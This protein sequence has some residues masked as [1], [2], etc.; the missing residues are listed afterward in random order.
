MMPS[1][2]HEEKESNR[3]LFCLRIKIY[4]DKIIL[5]KIA[6]RVRLIGF[7]TQRCG[8]ERGV[9][10]GKHRKRRRTACRGFGVTAR[11]ELFHPAFCR[12]R[13]AFINERSGGLPLREEEQPR[14]QP[15]R[16][17]RLRRSS[18]ALH[19]ECARGWRH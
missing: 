5:S 8:I 16:S 15:E 13:L 9:F 14:V 10:N 1:L 6:Q 17:R 2:R 18:N 12:D 4:G 19:P 7:T 3:A 11:P